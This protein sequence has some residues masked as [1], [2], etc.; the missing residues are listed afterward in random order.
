M[1]HDCRSNHPFQRKKS[2]KSDQLVKRSTFTDDEFAKSSVYEWV[3]DELEND[4]MLSM[5][6]RITMKD[7]RRRVKGL[8]KFFKFFEEV[9]SQH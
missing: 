3:D 5:E 7:I 2:F 8:K 6:P 9:F 4:R 1:K